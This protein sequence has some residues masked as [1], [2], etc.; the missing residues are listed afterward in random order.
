M[1]KDM[2]EN[3]VNTLVLAARLD[4]QRGARKDTVLNSLSRVVD[5]D[6]F[7]VVRDLV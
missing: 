7:L 6:L 4:I 5:R 2:T 1:K 3:Y